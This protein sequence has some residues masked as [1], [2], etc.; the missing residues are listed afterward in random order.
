MRLTAFLTGGHGDAARYIPQ[1]GEITG[2]LKD[3]SD[4]T[5]EE[6]AAIANFKSL[7]EALM[8]EVAAHTEAIER[9]TKL[10]GELGVKIAMMKNS[11]TDAEQAL[12]DD[13]KFLKDLDKTCETQTEE[14]QE[15]IKTRAL[16]L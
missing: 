15:R 11:L 12:V 7:I 2:I 9:K 1:S 5:A 13:T 10:V 4:A 14:W 8:K 3:L 16:E 6:E